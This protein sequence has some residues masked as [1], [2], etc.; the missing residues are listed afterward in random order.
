MMDLESMKISKYTILRLAK[1]IKAD[2]TRYGNDFECLIGLI[3]CLEN[4]GIMASV[5]SGYLFGQSHAWLHFID[6]Q[7]LD[8][9]S[10][11]FKSSSCKR[12]TSIYFG[13]PPNRY[14]L[15]QPPFQESLI[16]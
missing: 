1:I 10:K 5:Q 7:I 11:K 9:F 15:T 4:F 3:T 8:I 13:A 16:P 6:G 14:S 12:S 2:R